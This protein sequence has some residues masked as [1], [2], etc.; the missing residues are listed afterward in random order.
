[1]IIKE[2]FTL[3]KDVPNII[4]MP[5]KSLAVASIEKGS[6]KIAN[7]LDM[8]KNKIDHFTKNRVYSILENKNL[9]KIVVVNNETYILPVS[10]NIPTKQIIINLA[11]F[12]IDD[13][14]PTSPDPKNL[15]STLVYGICLSDLVSG[16]VEIP[17]KYF[18]VIST[19]LLSIFI[20]LFGKEFGLLG[21]Y[22]SEIPKLSF[23]ISCY[24]LSAFFDEVG[25]ESF[26]KAS[27]TSSFDYR[28]IE[29]ELNRYNFKSIED[30]ILS[31]SDFKVMPGITKVGFTAKFLKI[32]SL[33]F[34]PGLEDLSRF[35]SICSASTVSGSTIAPTFLGQKYNSGEFKKIIEITKPIFRR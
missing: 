1:M 34:L 35:M 5:S 26:R 17:S 21:T 11:P 24:I 22:A 33:N 15:Y 28:P 31:L 4:S 8:I 25:E 3:L 20:R 7:V 13:I 19:F 18:A 6:V 27:T 23:L 29:Q 9:N 12:G 30:F 10:Y 2:K 14:Y 16:K 32:L